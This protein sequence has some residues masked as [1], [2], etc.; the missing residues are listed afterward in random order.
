MTLDILLVTE[1][2]GGGSGRHVI[3]LARGLHRRGHRVAV[4]YSPVRAEAGFLAELRALPV[5]AH[6]VEMHRAVGPKDWASLQ[7]LS[8]LSQARG[9]FDILHGH[10]SKAGALVRML[11]GRL[12]ARVY[13]PHAF[14]TMDP[15]ISVPGK[16]VYG[17]VERLLA[18]HRGEAVIAVS[19][20]ELEHARELG[21]EPRKLHLVVNGVDA[22]TVGRA[23]ARE[24]L[25]LCP[26]DL[27]LGF[28][29]RLSVQKAPDRFVEV[30]DRLN[31]AG[32]PVK[33]VMLGDGELKADLSADIQARGLSDV[34]QLRSGLRGADHM[35]AF[36][37]FVMTSR[38]EAMPYVM[39]EA[40]RAGVPILSTAVGGS[41]EAVRHGETGFLVREDEAVEGLTQAAERLIQDP[42][43]RSRLAA[44]SL[45]HGAGLSI[46]AMVE[47]TEAVYRSTLAPSHANSRAHSS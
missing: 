18:N 26:D 38:Y 41:A 3:D 5:E 10:S 7:G 47:A 44:A 24:R 27:V 31:R 34:I 22:P 15:A 45:H 42:A 28:V 46:D 16:L 8:A 25:G 20:A 30:L 2:S 29:G 17:G 37:A 14:R 35:A 11:P 32:H 12:G 4:V 40:V 21:I 43:L 9:P 1:P 36:D 13:T 23:A 33:G 6:P 19:S 39:L